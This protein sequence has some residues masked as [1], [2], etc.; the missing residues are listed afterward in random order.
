MQCLQKDANTPNNNNN[1]NNNDDDAS[2]TKLTWKVVTLQKL[3]CP[4]PTNPDQY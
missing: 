2:C 1:D 4:S 3:T